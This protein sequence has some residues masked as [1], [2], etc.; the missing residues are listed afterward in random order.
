MEVLPPHCFYL[1]MNPLLYLG[2]AGSLL[3]HS[4]PAKRDEPVL[5]APDSGGVWYISRFGSGF[6]VELPR[7]GGFSFWFPFEKPTE[8]GL[9]KRR[10][11]L[12]GLYFHWHRSDF[13][14]VHPGWLRH[15]M[16]P[17]TLGIECLRALAGFSGMASP[18]M[19][20]FFFSL[21][22]WRPRKGFPLFP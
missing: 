9:P 4:G 12:F 15:A 21:Q 13:P 8:R 6:F 2:A 18:K 11:G 7:N 14:L 17:F 10:T 3:P 20:G 1:R 5:V 16:L 19:H 22:A